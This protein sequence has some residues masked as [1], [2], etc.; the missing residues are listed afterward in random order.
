[1]NAEDRLTDR[2]MAI[3]GYGTDYKGVL[4]DGTVTGV[5]SY[6]GKVFKH[7]VETGHWEGRHEYWEQD[8][9][10]TPLRT[11]LECL[12]TKGVTPRMFTEEV[13]YDETHYQRQPMESCKMNGWRYNYHDKQRFR[14][15]VLRGEVEL[16][17]PAVFFRYGNI[18]IEDGYEEEVRDLF[19]NWARSNS[20]QSRVKTQS[21]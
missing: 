10:A 3:E 12:A 8:Y 11:A 6:D 7:Y 4:P 16:P 1:M 5:M 2:E 21:D 20:N 13:V 19:W 14:R 15:L 18:Y 17:A 9:E